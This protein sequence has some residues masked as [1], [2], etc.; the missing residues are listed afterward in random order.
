M[1]HFKTQPGQSESNLESGVQANP[2]SMICDVY[3]MHI[4]DNT[5][6]HR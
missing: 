3:R 6:I 5:H 2:L 1:R 4:M